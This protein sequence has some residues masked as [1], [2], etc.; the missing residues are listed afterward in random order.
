MKES[1]TN[2]ILILLGDLNVIPPSVSPSCVSLS[3]QT[4]QKYQT[5]GWSEASPVTEAVI[6]KKIRTKLLMR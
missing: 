2:V 4:A 3:K 5:V 6:K 1:T